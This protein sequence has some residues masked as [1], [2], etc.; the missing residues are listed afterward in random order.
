[1]KLHEQ[2]GRKKESGKFTRS[3]G[4]GLM[5]Q[6]RGRSD[7]RG[8]G[9]GKSNRGRSKSRQGRSKSRP[10]NNKNTKGC[11]ICGKEGHW[12]RECPDK[13]QFKTQDS[14]NVVAESK[15]PLILTVSTQYAKDE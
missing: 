8:K 14:A 15:E 1:M 11:F 10:R 2:Q 5:V 7:N 9:N 13:K 4:E 3:G 6:D 12:K